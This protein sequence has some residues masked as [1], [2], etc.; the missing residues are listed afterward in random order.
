[1]AAGILMLLF[2]SCI[3]ASII[4]LKLLVLRFRLLFDTT[5][6]NRTHYLRRWAAAQTG[7]GSQA[8]MGISPLRGSLRAALIAFPCLQGAVT[9]RKY[10]YRLFRLW[11]Y[12][13]PKPFSGWYLSLCTFDTIAFTDKLLNFSADGHGVSPLLLF[14]L[15]LNS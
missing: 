3:P 12:G 1:M 6:R 4:Q 7:P 11:Q 14:V 2:Q 15:T 10:H 13:L 5:S 8:V 9:G